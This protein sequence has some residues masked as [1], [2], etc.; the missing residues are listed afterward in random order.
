MALSNERQPDVASPSFP[1]IRHAPQP[2]GFLRPAVALLTLLI[3]LAAACSTLGGRPEAADEHFDAGFELSGRHA[4]TAAIARFDAA[5][6]LDPDFAL[7]YDYRARAQLEFGNFD[8]A[9]ADASR[10]IDLWER[11]LPDR[12]LHS[13]LTGVYETRAVAHELLGNFDSAARDAE[14]SREFD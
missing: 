13:I 12:R 3:V 6:D 2:P 9:I 4:W 1:R 7:A 10:A 5:I 8:A 14:R 11:R